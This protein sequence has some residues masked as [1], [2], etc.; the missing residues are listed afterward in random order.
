MRFQFGL[1]ELHVNGVIF[2]G[3]IAGR[4]SEGEHVIVVGILYG[5]F[6]FSGNVVIRVQD[7]A[8]ALEGEN[9]EGKIADLCLFPGTHPVVNDSQ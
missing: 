3:P 7:A 2:I 4:R 9:L 1:V 6:D 5:G 8:A